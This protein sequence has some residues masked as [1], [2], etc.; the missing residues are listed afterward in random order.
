MYNLISSFIKLFFYFVSDCLSA[1]ND[2]SVY[3]FCPRSHL[4]Y[5][6]NE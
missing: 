6:Q 4:S 5:G 3:F 2:V 1:K